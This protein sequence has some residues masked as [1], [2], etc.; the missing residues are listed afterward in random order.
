[1]SD[2]REQEKLVALGINRRQAIVRLA[3][4]AGAAAAAPGLAGAAD[5]SPVS[6][7]K[8][9]ANP[10]DPDLVNPV[11]PWKK[12]LTRD[13]IITTAAVCDVILPGDER[14]PAPSKVEVP[15][16]I[17]E[18]VSA[19]YPRQKDDLLIIRG[20]L[21]WLNTE[22]NRRFGRRFPDLSLL[23]KTAICD[24]IA[25]EKT[26]RKRFQAGARFFDR[27]RYLT[28]LGFFTTIEGMKDL[29]YVGNVP[30]PEWKG[31][32]PEILRRLKVT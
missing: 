28:V 3:T 14:S 30:L 22:S 21:A 23:Q 19:P 8:G 17:D 11:L 31:P 5:D 24:D 10:R 12:I 6:P 9:S 7:V 20:G 27:M 26:A 15:D 1:M 25:W 4:A 29:G 32:P 13:E 18:W 2:E 16:F